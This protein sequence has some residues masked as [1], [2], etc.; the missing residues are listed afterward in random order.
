MRP[1]GLR[2]RVYLIILIATVCIGIAGFMAIE[3][4][5]FVDALYFNIVTIATVGYGDI[6]PVSG[7]GKLLAIALIIAGVGSFVGVVANA[8]EIMIDSRDRR[9]RRTKLNMI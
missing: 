3:H 2:L 4:L 9:L 7:P 5:S 8:V 6:H 1:V